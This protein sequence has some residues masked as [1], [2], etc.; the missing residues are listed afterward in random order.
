MSDQER[1]TG[2]GMPERVQTGGLR[3]LGTDEGERVE[4]AVAPAAPDELRARAREVL[5]AEFEHALMMKEKMGA[6]AAIGGKEKGRDAMRASERLRGLVASL[7]GM[8]KFALKMGLL[9]PAET[10]ELFADA[11]KKGLHEGWTEGA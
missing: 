2:E 9:T 7:E 5:R 10:R 1:A 4:R 11:M 3:T 6:E 8:S